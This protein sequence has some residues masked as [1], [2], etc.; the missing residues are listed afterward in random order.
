MKSI[1]RNYTDTLRRYGQRGVD[2]LSAATPVDSGK[3]ASA[4]SYEIVNTKDGQK[5]EWH[6][7]NVAEY[8][9]VVILLVYGHGCQNGSYV[10]GVNFVNPALEPLF[11]SMAEE[12]LKEV[13]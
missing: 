9:P 6:N 10:E 5:L 4:W 12:L 7:S 1:N 2:L 8:V 11:K 3:T 13:N